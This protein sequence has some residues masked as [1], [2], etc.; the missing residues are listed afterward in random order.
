MTSACPQRL[1][2][3]PPASLRL[4]S[5]ALI[6][7]EKLKCLPLNRSRPYLGVCLGVT[8]R[9]AIPCVR[10]QNLSTPSQLQAFYAANGIRPLSSVVRS[11]SAMLPQHSLKKNDRLL[12]PPEIWTLHH[13]TGAVHHCT[14]A[15]RQIMHS[16]ETS[17]LLCHT[18]GLYIGLKKTA[19]NPSQSA[20]GIFWQWQFSWVRVS[21]HGKIWFLKCTNNSLHRRRGA[22][23][24]NSRPPPPSRTPRNFRTHLSSI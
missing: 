23:R 6:P 22:A 8:A 9:A 1:R 2:T 7:V 24:S 17:A 19:L 20:S 11:R 10:F 14:P 15:P 3:C 13:V 21:H 5:T 12:Q 16:V 18:A 4:L